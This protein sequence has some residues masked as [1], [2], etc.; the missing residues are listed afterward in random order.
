MSPVP[1]VHFNVGLPEFTD[2]FKLP[3][4]LP[5]PILITVEEAQQK[6]RELGVSSPTHFLSFL[7]TYFFL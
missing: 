2:R 6:L 4:E 7:L 1:G 5:E 3:E